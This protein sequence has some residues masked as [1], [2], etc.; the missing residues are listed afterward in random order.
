M[1]S[2]SPAA[3]FGRAFVAFVPLGF[4]SVFF[5]YPVLAMLWRGLGDDPGRFFDALTSGFFLRI[6]WFTLWQAVASTALTALVAFPM[7]W[8]VARYRFRGRRLAR[9]LATVPFVLPTVVVAGAFLALLS[10]L[11]F[12]DARHSVPVVLAAHVFF[13]IAVFVRTVGGFW[14]RLDRSPEQAAQVLGASPWRAFREVTT[15]RLRPAILSAVSIV[16]LFTFT[17]F[18]IIIIL[19]GPRMQTVETEIYRYAI[20]RTDFGTAAALGT[21]QLLVVLALVA[22]NTR[23]TRMA[24]DG[25]R[26]QF[27]QDHAEP[28]ATLTDRLRVASALLPTLGFLLLP[29]GA[30][31]VR[32]FRRSSQFSLANFRDLADR[33][34]VLP[35]TP[36]A[37]LTNSV[38]FALTATGMAV[39]V[40]GLA[41][42]VIVHGRKTMS[43]VLDLG[44]ILPL[45]TSA[46]TLGLGMLISLDAPPLNLRASWWIVPIAQAMIGIPFVIR[47]VVPV[48]RSV[49]DRMREAAAVL[50]AAPRRVRWEIDAALAM[51]ALAVG[52]GFAFAISLGEFG[53]TL[54]LGR[55]PELLT[56]PL[57]IERL[58]G[59]PGELLRGQAM[60]LAVVL[61][62]MTTLVM[63]LAD[64][65]GR[66]GSPERGAI[67]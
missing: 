46:V 2:P 14:G 56:M 5:L 44:L 42:L 58:L 4:L 36:L 3:A 66:G 47:S 17:S 20:N 41:S 40:G 7:T 30:L 32:A 6:A 49:D 34:T 38:A 23:L 53:A 50:G 21:V 11:G 27:A 45:G 64:R 31:T 54:M 13:N 62:L 16:F 37:S 35:I 39:V 52:A 26:E 10:W 48:L 8:A 22:W 33:P 29:I 59:Q 55:N 12:E 67:L 9:A 28:A 61:M 51:Q 43:R 65:P 18:G 24:A 60:A 63:L 57:A 25:S 15:P 1:N 19:G